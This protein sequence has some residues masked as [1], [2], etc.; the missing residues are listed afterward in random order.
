[1]SEL[2]ITLRVKHE[3]SVTET[4]ILKDRIKDWCDEFFLEK[5]EL[6]VKTPFDRKTEK[7][8]EALDK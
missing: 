2:K 5:E 6:S 3:P 8:Y 7:M 1:M 4:Q